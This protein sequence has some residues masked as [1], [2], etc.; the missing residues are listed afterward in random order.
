MGTKAEQIAETEVLFCDVNQQIA[1]TAERFGIGSADFY[2]EC[3]DVS[4]HERM[5]VPLDEYETV[6]SESARFIVGL[7]HEVQ[8][9]E[10][11]LRSALCR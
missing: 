3:A 10:A 11:R 5:E 9:V 8:R 2:C 4:C 1:D 6:R 7:G